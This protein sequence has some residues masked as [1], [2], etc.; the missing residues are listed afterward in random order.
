MKGS[1]STLLLVA[2]GSIGL[3]STPALAGDCT[4]PVRTIDADRRNES[5]C[6][7]AET[8]ADAIAFISNFGGPAREPLGLL[9]G[10][11][12]SGNLVPE[13]FSPGL[14][15]DWSV[16]AFTYDADG[17]NIPGCTI[18]IDAPVTFVN[19]LTLQPCQD[20]VTLQ[21]FGLFTR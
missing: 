16:F 10:A 6:T 7:D 18:R 9:V 3:A 21:S 19:E 4:G 17:R 12:Q 5:I 8:G 13:G 14:A 20:A 2:I 15:R 11:G 1:P